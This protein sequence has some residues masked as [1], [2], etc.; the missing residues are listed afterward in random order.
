MDAGH[1]PSTSTS[2]D[3][4]LEPVVIR[5]LWA[6][7]IYKFTPTLLVD[8]GHSFYFFL[9]FLL[10]IICF[11]LTAAAQE[12]PTTPLVQARDHMLGQCV[13]ILYTYRKFCATAS[14][15][16]QLILPEALKLLPLYSMGMCS[17]LFLKKSTIFVTCFILPRDYQSCIVC[18]KE[19]YTQGA[20]M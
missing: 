11:L 8:A 17:Y 7:Y 16:G 20:S 6:A 19:V 4:C 2:L 9:L 5:F 12:V 10:L 3:W 14:S 13:T 1:S 18:R 15:S